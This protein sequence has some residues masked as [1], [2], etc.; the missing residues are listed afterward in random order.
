MDSPRLIIEYKNG[1]YMYLLRGNMGNGL[2]LGLLGANLGLIWSVGEM[3]KRDSKFWAQFFFI[4]G[5]NWGRCNWE[6]RWR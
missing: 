5:L 6:N 4:C 3:R 2:R 1:Q